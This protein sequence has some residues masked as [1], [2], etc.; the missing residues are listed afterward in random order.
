[1]IVFSKVRRWLDGVNG[2]LQ[3]VIA[4]SS[5]NLG[6]DN[7][8]SRDVVNAKS[9]TANNVSYSLSRTLSLG[10]LDSGL[11]KHLLELAQS[12]LS[13]KQK[14]L[15][16]SASQE[17]AYDSMTLTR[18]SERLSRGLKMSYSTVKWN[19][20]RLRVLKLLYGG[21]EECKGTRAELTPLGRLIT[22]MLAQNLNEQQSNTVNVEA[23]T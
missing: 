5:S 7:G 20:K 2:K 17:L 6:L 4:P 21:S 10:K 8:V 15:L 11:G 22:S 9:R 3:E 18:L 13:E 1:V 19:L 12:V 23:P 16:V 14:F